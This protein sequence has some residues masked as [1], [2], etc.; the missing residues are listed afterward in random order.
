MTSTS[1]SGALA[2]RASM[3]RYLIADWIEGKGPGALLVAGLHRGDLRGF[4]RVANHGSL[5]KR[6]PSA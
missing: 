2:A 4:D 3:S 1:S 6:K 5:S